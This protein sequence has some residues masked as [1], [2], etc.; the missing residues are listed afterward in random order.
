MYPNPAGD[1]LNL[2][3]EMGNSFEVYIFDLRG[4]LVIRENNKNRIMLNDLSNG[5]YIVKVQFSNYII[6]RKLIIL[7]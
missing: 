6:T 2:E 3:P 4:R 7:R 1:F 5:T